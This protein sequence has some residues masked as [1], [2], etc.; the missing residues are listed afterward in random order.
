MTL[1]CL[2]Q[3]NEKRR[4]LKKQDAR[5]RGGARKVMSGPI[6]NRPFQ[7]VLPSF[8]VCF[9]PFTPSSFLKASSRPKY[10]KS[11]GYRTPAE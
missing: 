3:G 9:C 7:P 6:G 1:V 11:C 8:A 2:P 5:K 10:R 4:C